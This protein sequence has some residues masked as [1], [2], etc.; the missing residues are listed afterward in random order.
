[1]KDIWP[2]IYLW[3]KL[4]EIAHAIVQNRRVVIP[5][6]HG[7]GK[8]WLMARI[9][10]WFLYCFPPAKV[11]TTAPTWTQVESVLWSEI[12]KAYNT[13]HIPLD[14]RL[15]TTDLKIEDD[16]FALGFSTKGRAS[17]RD[18]GAPKFQGFH[19]KNLLVA[20]DEGP[21]V[22]HDIWVAIEGLISATN[23]R[24]IAPGNPTS[25]TGDFYNACKSPLWTKINISCFDHPNVQ[26]GKIL[27]PGA[28]TREWVE[29]RRQEWGEDS[30]L[31][32]AKVLGQ[33]PAEGT[34]TLIPLAW[35]EAC[36]G[37]GLSREGLKTLGGDVA[38]YGDDR[39]ALARI[40]GQ[41]ALPIEAVNKKDTNWTTGRVIS[42]NNTEKFDAIGVDDTGVGGGVT[43]ALEDAGIDVEPFNFG[44][45][46]YD[47]D[48]FE[49][50]KAEIYWNLR[51]AIKNKTLELPDDKELI[52]E[53]CSIKFSYTRKGKIKIE[54]KD[55]LKKRG[56]RSP[57]K[58]DAL[59]IAYSAGRSLNEAKVSVITLGG[60]DE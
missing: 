27:V 42:L 48:T 56:L 9:V 11:I 50:L 25:P 44:A 12:K 52:N 49:N 31:W 24:V 58:A 37:L 35:A 23:N 33:F 2:D 32:Q 46:P 18:Y 17:E 30:P 41:V 40:Y 34:D 20:L 10:L 43:D 22:E 19:A 28:V 21:G 4:E 57:D 53:L 8:S 29:E 38:R 45:N 54:S 13:A 47:T 36:V 60:D 14:G 59:A 51:E 55:D 5:S 39:T 1:M 16:W 15:L 3:D 6:G 26:T 7:V